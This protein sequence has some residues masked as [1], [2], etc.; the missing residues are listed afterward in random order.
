MNHKCQQCDR[1][2]TQHSVE[3][4]K[5]KKIE[6]H[7]CDLCAAKEGVD[8][9]K[10]V[11]AGVTDIINNLVK[12]QS[13]IRETTEPVNACDECGLTFGE[14]REHSLLGCPHCYGEFEEPLGRLLERAHEGESRHQGKIPHRSGAGEGRQV[15]LTRMRKRLDEAVETEDYELAARLRDDIHQI[16]EAVR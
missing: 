4:V 3:V 6:K 13:G 8:A 15:Q 1:K 2:A 16:E 12:A 10:V 7:L 14:F 9:G 5:G 11:H